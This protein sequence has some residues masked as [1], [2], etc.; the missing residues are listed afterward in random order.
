MSQIKDSASAVD[1]PS[2]RLFLASGPAAAVF[3]SLHR[4][5]AAESPLAELIDEHRKAAAVFEVAFCASDEAIRFGRESDEFR[6]ADEWHDETFFAMEEV[7]MRL[8]A[9]P[10]RSL[11]EA[12][13][14]ISY[15]LEVRHDLDH[16][17]VALLHSFAG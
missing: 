9:E 17:L 16:D 1:L 11:A 7:F 12:Q 3:A 2:R 4:G 8:C 14:K 10:I 5:A 6:R 13:L 15:V